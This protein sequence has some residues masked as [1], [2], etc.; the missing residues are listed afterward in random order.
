[1]YGTAGTIR[2]LTCKV[3]GHFPLVYFSGD[4]ALTVVLNVRRV[5]HCPD[6]FGMDVT[7]DQHTYICSGLFINQNSEWPSNLYRRIDIVLALIV[8]F[9]YL[10]TYTNIIQTRLAI[11]RV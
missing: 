5:C 10:C 1:M 11:D 3:R 8:L 7:T 4:A 2:C 6:L 9:F